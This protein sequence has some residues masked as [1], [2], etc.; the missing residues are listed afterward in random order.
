MSKEQG[1]FGTIEVI[2]IE[3]ATDVSEI[4]ALTIDMMNN[5]E[6]INTVVDPIDIKEID[7][8]VNSP[9]DIPEISASYDKLDDVT[10]QT[11]NESLLQ[12]KITLFDT[13][14]SSSTHNIDRLIQYMMRSSSNSSTQDDTDQVEDQSQLNINDMYRNN[15]IRFERTLYNIIDEVM[16]E[17][18]R[19]LSQSNQDVTSDNTETSVHNRLVSA[20]TSIAD[21][22]SDSIESLSSFSSTERDDT[23]TNMISSMKSSLRKMIDNVASKYENTDVIDSINRVDLT[24]NIRQIISNNISNFYTEI[25]TDIKNSLSTIQTII[26]DMESDNI[27][28]MIDELNT[29]SESMTSND[30]TTLDKL[31][32]MENNMENVAV[33]IDE[34]ATN[35][36]STDIDNNTMNI[37]NDIP[38]S[39]ISFNS[40]FTSIDIITDKLSGDDIFG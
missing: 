38:S 30:N 17:V 40:R 37:V 7:S 31:S 39:N 10:R 32:D 27:I 1:I 26:S 12:S 4:E 22:I 19:T 28:N 29:L 3:E 13:D 33:K 15:S 16:D 23:Y 18:K 9:E 6:L 35:N 5:L 8:V 14:I 20:K 21:M 25:S 36:T 11:I 24:E 34:I 2:G